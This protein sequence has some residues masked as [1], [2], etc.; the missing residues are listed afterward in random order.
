MLEKRLVRRSSA[1][2]PR[3]RGWGTARSPAGNCP[4]LPLSR[5]P[6]RA[7]DGHYSDSLLADSNNRRGECETFHKRLALLP[8][9]SPPPSLS[10]PCGRRGGRCST[11]VDCV[12]EGLHVP[13][14]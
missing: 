12:G 2:P 5:R 7:R 11:E 9:S 4:A 1:T 6:P 13:H 3:R 8:S 10:S 14:A